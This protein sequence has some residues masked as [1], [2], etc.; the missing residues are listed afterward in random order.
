MKSIFSTLLKIIVF[1]VGLQLLVLVFRPLR[2]SCA[3]FFSSL[4]LEPRAIALLWGVIVVGA[5]MS[6]IYGLRFL[7]KSKLKHKK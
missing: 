3:S 2:T 4:G 1:V 5:A 7:V 6:I